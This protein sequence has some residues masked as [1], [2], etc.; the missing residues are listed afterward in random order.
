VYTLKG[1]LS[2]D[3]SNNDTVSASTTPSTQWSSP[4][5]QT[6]GTTLT[7]SATPVTG[8]TFTAK[9]AAIVI[10]TNATDPS[11]QNVV[12]GVQDFVFTKVTFDGTASGEDVRFS[13]LSFNVRT[14]KGSTGVAGTDG[15]ASGASYP[16]NCQIWDGTGALNTG[17]NMVTPST[18]GD[19]TFTLDN[20]L[21]VTKGTFKVVNIGCDV[22]GSSVATDTI[23]W[24]LPTSGTAIT[25]TG[26]TSGQ[27]AAITYTAAQAG[28][29]MTLQTGGSLTVTLDP[30]SPSA[31]LAAA[32]TT[33]VTLAVLRVHATNEAINLTNLAFKLS[34]TGNNTPQD[35]VQYTVWDGATLVGSGVFNAFDNSTTTLTAATLIPKDGDKI[36]TVKGD[37]NAVGTSLPGG[38]GDHVVVDHDTGGPTGLGTRGTGVSSGGSIND[39]SALDT[40]SAGVRMFRSIPTV[41][42]LSVPTNT[43]N[44]GTMSLYRFKVT[45]DAKGDVGL[46]KFTFVI[47]TSSTVTVTNVI[48]Y[49]YSDSAYSVP[50]YANGGRLNSTAI[51]GWTTGADID[52]KFDPAAQGGAGT[53]VIQ[54]PA[55]TSRY[56]D[57][58]ATIGGTVAAGQSVQT[59][60][61]GDN[62]SATLAKATAVDI[63]STAQNNFIWS[64]NATTTSGFGNVDW[65]NGVNITGL[66]ST[67]L[68][69]EVV[70]K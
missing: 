10:S 8:N 53:E 57:V 49:G 7:L 12:A 27:S 23:K 2:T 38:Q 61:Q 69:P 5:G 29:V 16:T 36:L 42:K 18:D 3:F 35:L 62:A 32:N 43:L 66:P 20:Q 41:A 68:S 46:Y 56:F 51:N 40:A 9:A 34:D 48:V 54:V 64:G 70:S 44:A 59:Q 22:S 25:G 60:L 4:V 1:K 26:V 6:T 24:S 37:L 31:V 15:V 39:S 55:G 11:A 13:T 21:I 65:A 63:L 28:P 67:N 19:K 14:V 47:A 50:A 17:S 52:V 58:T 30:A 33:N 45:A